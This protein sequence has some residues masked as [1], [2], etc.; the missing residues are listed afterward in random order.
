VTPYPTR[1]R[2]ARLF[3]RSSWL[4]AAILVAAHSA[5]AQQALPPRSLSLEEAISIARQHNPTFL[6]QQNDVGVAQWQARQARADFLPSANATTSFG[7]QTSGE[8]RVG[9][10]VLGE[11]PAYRSSSYNLGLQ[12]SING[13]K[14]LQP[15]ATRSQLHAV[16]QR[17]NN[18]EA[19][20]S[21]QVASQYLSVLQAQE[22]VAQAQ[23][24]VERTGEHVRLAEARLEVGA[25]TQL[26]V[27]RAEVQQG[28]AEIQLIQAENA[29]NTALLALGQSL[30]TPLDPQTRLTSEF[31]VFAPRWQTD[32]LIQR[33]MGNNPGLISARASR[34]VARIGVRQ[35]NSAYLPSLNFNM[36]LNGSVFSAAD[37]EPLV[38]QQL[39]MGSYLGCLD[40]NKINEVAGLPQRNCRHPDDPAARDQV[41]QQ[42][43]ASNPNWPF[44]YTRQPLSGSISISIPIYN[45][46]QREVQV[47]QA[48]Q[49]AADAEYQVRA[50]E[51][52]MR[53]DVA[54]ALRNLET[55]HRTVAIQERVR[56]TAEEELRLAQERFRFGAASSVE[57]TDAQ[58]NLGD[59]ERG[60]IEVVYTFHQ[61][62]AVLESLVG[63]PL[64]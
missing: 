37:I 13:S 18:A 25:G 11:R 1:S 22:N 24:Q 7:Y 40:Q 48:R 8:Q 42:V 53:T 16:E 43:A 61:A 2:S 31:E 57:V 28:Q 47:A 64:R 62:L 39:T 50:Q 23:R 29:L 32:E 10:I 9:A 6:S 12:L 3:R 4:L 45:G 36:N 58:T 38:D 51:L 21:S 44:G 34:D 55:A 52:Q 33:A 17:I 20:L 26:D 54:T 63:E 49:Q 30:G 46:L 35:A 5:A 56:A 60:V 15:A 59:A 19:T 14:L 41:R 27:R